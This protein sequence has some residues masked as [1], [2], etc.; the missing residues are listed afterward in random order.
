MID[1]KFGDVVGW[2]NDGSPVR[3]MLISPVSR[4]NWRAAWAVAPEEDTGQFPW[5]LG[6][7]QTIGV[8]DETKVVSRG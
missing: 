4:V 7:V 2:D 8:N 6:E 5:E 3:W 1:L